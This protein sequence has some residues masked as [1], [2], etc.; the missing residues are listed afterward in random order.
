MRAAGL[1]VVLAIGLLPQAAAAA[2]AP[3]VVQVA[4]AVPGSYI[5]TLKP[6]A[7]TSA[8]GER[9]LARSLAAGHGGKVTQVYTTVMDGFAASGLTEAE[10]KALASDPAVERVEQDGLVHG[11]GTQGGAPLG[12][13]RIDQRGGRDGK[14]TFANATP[15]AGVNVYVMD[16]GI[17]TGHNDFGGRASVAV[18]TYG[19]DGSDCHGH[20]THVAGTV[21]GGTYGVAKGVALRAVK[22][23]GCDNTGAGSNI[24]GGLDWIAANA[25]KPAVVNM[26]LGGD[27]SEN[28]ENAVRRVIAKGITVVVSAGNDNKDVS[29]QGPANVPEAITVAATDGSDKR[30]S[31]S[32]FGAGVDLFAPGVGIRSAMIGGPDNTDVWEG[33]SMAAPHVTGMVAK[34]LQVNPAATPAEVASVITGD[35]TPDVVSDPKGSPNRLAYSSPN[36][37][38][39]GGLDVTDGSVISGW[40]DD[41]SCP[42]PVDVTITADPPDDDPFTIATVKADQTAGDHGPHGFRLEHGLI[43]GSVVSATAAGRD[44]DCNPDGGDNPPLAAS[45]RTVPAGQSLPTPPSGPSV[46]V[47]VAQ[48]GNT[49]TGL[50]ILNGS[51]NTANTTVSYVRSDGTVAASQ[52]VDVPGGESVTR[53]DKA[54]PGFSGSAVVTSVQGGADLSVVSNHIRGNRIGSSTGVQRQGA[55]TLLLPL[56]KKAHYGSTTTFAVQNTTRNPITVEV[57]YSYSSRSY[58]DSIPPYATKLY[59]QAEAPDNPPPLFSARVSSFNGQIAATVLEESDGLPGY[60]TPSVLEYAAPPVERASTSLSAPLVVANNWQKGFTGIQVQNT[61]TEKTTV[62]VTYGPNGATS[63]PPGKTKCGTPASTTKEADAGQFATFLQTEAENT[64]F[65]GCVYVGAATITTEGLAGKPAQPIVAVV[66]QTG[67][68]TGSSAYEPPPTSSLTGTARM[69]LIQVNNYGTTGGLQI[70]NHG[71]AAGTVT[72]TYGRNTAPVLDPSQ[73]QPPPCASPP[74]TKSGVALAALESKTILL[75]LDTPEVANCRYIGNVTV[76]STSPG[77]TVGVLANQVTAGMIDGLGTYV[78]GP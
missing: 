78:G 61:G 64:S 11:D 51:A 17:Y 26:S 28:R 66:N 43:A 77:V 27:P 74:D 65:T 20:G 16:S 73:R 18:D 1:G 47:P 63:I 67:D 60:T 70:A 23:L 40:A 75:P 49:I 35:A 14:Y 10:A 30:A 36:A 21:G 71:T 59:R 58:G 41:R 50:Q 24:I 31:F 12:L 56:L 39:R 72:I 29:Q 4:D 52:A 22:V 37:G 54:P 13:D 53:V 6:S 3:A 62:R 45:P 32:N 8:T 42:G 46:F 38:A 69:P 68:G 55:T 44:G 7:A 25:Q 15:G 33:T 34:Y 2:P 48:R 19:G 9:A 57:K 5:V 76:S